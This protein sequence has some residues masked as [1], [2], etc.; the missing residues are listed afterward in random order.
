MNLPDEA[1]DSHAEHDLCVC[2]ASRRAHENKLFK[3]L[4]ISA[5]IFY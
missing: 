4:I 3:E 1:T 5:L 2:P